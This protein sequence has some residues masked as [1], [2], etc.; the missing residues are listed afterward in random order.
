MQIFQERTAL[1]FD[2]LCKARMN[3][4]TSEQAESNGA[5]DLDKVEP[6]N[7]AAEKESPGSDM[8][9]PSEGKDSDLIECSADFC[10]NPGLSRCA[11]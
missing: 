1:L 7:Q 11:R 6:Q 2:R 4:L 10:H 5:D 3:I 9:P 8:R